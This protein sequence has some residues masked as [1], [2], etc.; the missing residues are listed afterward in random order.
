VRATSGKK[1][2]QTHTEALHSTGY[3]LKV[4]GDDFFKKGLIFRVF[5]PYSDHTDFITRVRPSEETETQ[6]M[7]AAV[8]LNCF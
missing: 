8:P 3:R 6:K 5:L 4:S 7:W 2:L 1:T